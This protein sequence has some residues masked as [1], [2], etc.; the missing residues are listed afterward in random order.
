MADGSEVGE[1]VATESK[2]LSA[3]L[4]SSDRNIMVWI[5]LTSEYS[6]SQCMC[7]LAT[8]ISCLSWGGFM[9]ERAEKR[10]EER[11]S[12]PSNGTTSSQRLHSITAPVPTDSSSYPSIPP[13]LMN[14]WMA[15]TPGEHVFVDFEQ[16]G[17]SDVVFSH[18]SVQHDLRALG[19]RHGDLI[20]LHSVFL[21]QTKPAETHRCSE[22]ITHL[23]QLQKRISETHFSVLKNTAQPST[24]FLSCSET[25]LARDFGQK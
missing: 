6:G 14:S 10:T 19:V 5:N 11:R 3:M 15:L 9:P 1:P 7:A 18:H 25:S 12:S 21:D 22:T 13:S 16:D 17:H 2:A 20:E 4:L 24:C 8:R 23:P